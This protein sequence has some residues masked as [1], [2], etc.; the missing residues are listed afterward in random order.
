MTTNNADIVRLSVL[1]A[2]ETGSEQRRRLAEAR[3]GVSLLDEPMCS[4]RRA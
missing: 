4:T 2:D 3:K 1:L